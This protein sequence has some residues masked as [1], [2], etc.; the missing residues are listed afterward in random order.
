MRNASDVARL[1]AAG[2]RGFLI[3]EALMQSEDPQALIAAL[4]RGAAGQAVG[5][6]R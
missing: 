2:A 4:R 1:R 5:V 3:G 6:D